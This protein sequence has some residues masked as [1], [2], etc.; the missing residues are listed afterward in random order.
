MT[1]ETCDGKA[2]S[3]NA[4]HGD[5]ADAGSVAEIDCVA[6]A[7]FLEKTKQSFGQYDVAQLKWQRDLF[8]DGGLAPASLIAIYDHE[9]SRRRDGDCKAR[10]RKVKK[11]RL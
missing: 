10:R 3:E 8:L 4:S 11:R 9:I 6:L 7:A 5:A 1:T 2:Q